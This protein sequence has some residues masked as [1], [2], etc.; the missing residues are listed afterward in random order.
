MKSK[1]ILSHA[2]I[3]TLVL[4][5]VPFGAIAQAQEGGGGRPFSQQE[6]DQM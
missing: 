4:M 2:L 3:W 5:M 1:V 6:L